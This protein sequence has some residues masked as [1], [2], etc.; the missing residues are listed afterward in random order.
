MGSEQRELGIK[1][2][3]AGVGSDCCIEFVSPFKSNAFLEDLSFRDIPAK[4]KALEV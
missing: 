1:T 4:I 3:I 2:T